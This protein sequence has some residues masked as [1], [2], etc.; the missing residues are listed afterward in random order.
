MSALDKGK[1]REIIPDAPSRLSDRDRGVN[2]STDSRASGKSNATARLGDQ[3]NSIWGSSNSA[4]PS[5]Q[6]TPSGSPF[7]EVTALNAFT[8]VDPPKE[9]KPPSPLGA[10]TPRNAPSQPVVVSKPPSPP[11]TSASKVATPKGAA[12]PHAPVS[13]AVA[14]AASKVPT[15]A[16]SSIGTPQPVAKTLSGAGGSS[17][18][19]GG[20]AS[21][22]ST[23]AVSK[24]P[25]KAASK[26]ASKAPTPWGA[27]KAPT[28][29]S[30]SKMGTPTTEHPEPSWPVEVSTLR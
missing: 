30:L 1:S 10:I 21:K 4:V 8:H 19:T 14:Q 28:P 24:V 17:W 2:I 18:K 15:P 9:T 7:V 25:S 26:A 11:P 3:L 12:T 23:P 5:K 20:P 27:S 6:P 29:R 16:V 13:R 22:V